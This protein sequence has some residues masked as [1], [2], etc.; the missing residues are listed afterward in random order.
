MHV[1][2][3]SIRSD[4]L[5]V[6]AGDSNLKTTYDGSVGV[7]AN[8]N[9][10]IARATPSASSYNEGANIGVMVTNFDNYHN[11]VVV[12]GTVH[13]DMSTTND[14]QI[15]EEIPESPLVDINKLHDNGP[16]ITT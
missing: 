15:I 3:C 8:V 7:T 6:V 16:L 10:P 9:N 1:C 2:K 14:I 13:S 5:D 4:V 12:D 11:Y